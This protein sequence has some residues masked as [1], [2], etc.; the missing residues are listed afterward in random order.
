MAKTSSSSSS[1]DR[2]LLPCGPRT[3]FAANAHAHAFAN[4]LGFPFEGRVEGVLNRPGWS[5][6]WN[7][8]LFDH[9]MFSIFEP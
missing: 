6:V 8:E 7:V 5:D 9:S 4:W 1:Q 2:L 3:H